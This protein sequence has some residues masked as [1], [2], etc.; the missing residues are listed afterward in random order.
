M[1]NVLVT[2]LHLKRLPCFERSGFSTFRVRFN[3]HGVPFRL[4][5]S[6]TQYGEP[7]CGQSISISGESPAS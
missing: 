7:P 6:K 5:V 2:I 4:E 3:Q 1:A